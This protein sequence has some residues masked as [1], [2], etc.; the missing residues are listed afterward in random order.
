MWMK[1]AFLCSAGFVAAFVDAIA[2]GGG[3][4]SIPAFMVAGVSPHF[5]LGTNKFSATCGSLTSSLSYMKSG[6]TDNK[7]L[8]VLIPFTLVGA[9]LGVNT[10]L[11]IDQKY[12]Q[13]MVLVMVL[14]VGMYTLFSKQLGAEDNFKGLTKSSLAKGIVMAFAIGFYDG[15]FGPGTGSFLIFGFIKIFGY[16]F[17]SAGGNSKVLNFVSNIAS[18]IIFAFHGQILYMY[19]IP[20]AIAMIFGSNIGSKFAMKQGVKVMKPI[21]VTM[22]LGVA[23]KMLY[24]MFN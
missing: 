5:T 17:I 24:Q 14:F 20:V 1:L 3:L 15:F 9:V 22:S 21:F 6:K 10:V 11:L 2:G 18:L 7:V 12:L 8:K 13:T 16:D 23:V 19:G 4:I